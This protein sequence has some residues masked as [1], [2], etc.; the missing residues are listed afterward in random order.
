MSDRFVPYR[1]SSSRRVDGLVLTS[2]CETGASRR[3][4]RRVA[5]TLGAGMAGAV[6]LA[7]ILDL[8]TRPT[9]GPDVTE[10]EPYRATV[11]HMRMGE[12]ALSSG[13]C[14]DE[15]RPYDVDRALRSDEHT[16][17]EDLEPEGEGP[18]RR[19]YVRDDPDQGI[20]RGTISLVRPVSDVSVRQRRRRLQGSGP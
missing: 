1:I 11:V 2:E 15:S 9:L 16:R 17:A 5:A 12:V 3:R 13:P 10:T 20:I 14:G 8:A 19:R 7:G 18:A 6:L 4:R